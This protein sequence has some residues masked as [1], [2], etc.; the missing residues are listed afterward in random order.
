MKGDPV[1]QH[2]LSPKLERDRSRQGTPR[3]E[4]AWASWYRSP[5]WKSIRRHRLAEEPQ[6]RECAIEGRTVPASYVDHIEPHRGEWSLFMKYE[7]T[8]S[9][10]L[11]HHNAHRYAV[12]CGNAARLPWSVRRFGYE[13][14]AKGVAWLPSPREKSS[15]RLPRLLNTMDSGRRLLI[16][17]KRGGPSVN[18][19]LGI[20]RKAS[21]DA[22]HY[23][24]LLGLTPS[25]R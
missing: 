12:I 2:S 4:R 1:T 7:N 17:N 10:C 5:V 14:N 3:V 13:L 11:R 16:Q 15:R 21:R 23:A 6:C 19:L 25:A 8:Q 22:A 18:P 20:I 24:T 9:L